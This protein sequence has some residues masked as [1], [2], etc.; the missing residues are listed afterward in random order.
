MKLYR[1]YVVRCWQEVGGDLPIWRFALV[2]V[3]D[4]PQ[5]RGFPTFAE[6]VSFLSDDLGAVLA[7]ATFGEV[8]DSAAPPPAHFTQNSQDAL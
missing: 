1:S 3:G 7:Q 5:T 8:T 4:S 6:L 2:Q